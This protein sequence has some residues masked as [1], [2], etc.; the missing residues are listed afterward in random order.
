LKLTSDVESK[1]KKSSH[2]PVQVASN[3]GFFLF[4]G[5]THDKFYYYRQITTCLRKQFAKN[6]AFPAFPGDPVIADLLT[7][8]R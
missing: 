4:F 7:E 2:R 6:Y 5:H 8:T 3:W 1:T